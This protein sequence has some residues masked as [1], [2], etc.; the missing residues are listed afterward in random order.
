MAPVFANRSRLE[1]TVQWIFVIPFVLV[2]VSL[3]T[4]SIIYG[5]NAQD[6]F[7]IVVS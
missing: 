1:S 4:F 5:L 7:E 2:F 6:R 3:I